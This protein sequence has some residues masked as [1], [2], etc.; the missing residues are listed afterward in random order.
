MSNRPKYEGHIVIVDELSQ[1]LP[2][3]DFALESGEIEAVLPGSG[4]D[5]G[6]VALPGESGYLYNGNIN[7]EKQ[8]YVRDEKGNWFSD[9]KML[10][11]EGIT[12]KIMDKFGLGDRTDVPDTLVGS[13][14]Q[15]GPRM[16]RQ[17]EITDEQ[18]LS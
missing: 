2:E 3:Q 10:E 6:I 9:G 8:N 12:K 13:V 15:F 7:G 5:V 17:Y 14:N 4:G 18:E 1:L 11:D 16:R